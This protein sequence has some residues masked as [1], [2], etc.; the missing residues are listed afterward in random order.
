MWY[1]VWRGREGGIPNN[2]TVIIDSTF[3]FNIFIQHCIVSCL[4]H[5]TN[6]V[7]FS[8]LSLVYS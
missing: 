3:T 1:G 4:C 6:S 8:S 2:I 7:S 5:Q